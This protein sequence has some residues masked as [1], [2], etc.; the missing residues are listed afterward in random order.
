M[1]IHAALEILVIVCK[2]TLNYLEQG[3]RKMHFTLNGMWVSSAV[4]SAAVA[5]RRVCY[6]Q[7]RCRDFPARADGM[8]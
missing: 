3:Q 8:Q 7:H 6:F 1:H 5:L 4:D 2:K